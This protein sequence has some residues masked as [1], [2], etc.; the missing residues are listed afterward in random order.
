MLAHIDIRM[1]QD[2]TGIK[3]YNGILGVSKVYTFFIF[4]KY[5]FTRYHLNL[6]VSNIMGYTGR[7]KKSIQN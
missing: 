6:G 3:I 1:S 4:Q 2:D 7:F 5:K